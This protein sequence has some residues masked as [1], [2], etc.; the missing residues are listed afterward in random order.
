MFYYSGVD[1]TLFEHR[2]R[3]HPENPAQDMLHPQYAVFCRKM[4]KNQGT[5]YQKKKHVLYIKYKNSTISIT[6]IVQFQYYRR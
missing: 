4:T 2:F 3:V 5:P 6:T 1:I